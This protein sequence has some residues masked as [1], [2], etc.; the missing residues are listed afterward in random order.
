[1][2]SWSYRQQMELMEVET[3]PPGFKSCSLLNTP[4]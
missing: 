3:R 2:C 1:M 4:P